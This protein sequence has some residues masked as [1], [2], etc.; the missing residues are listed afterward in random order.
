MI[1]IEN[2]EARDVATLPTKLGSEFYR[3]AFLL[4]GSP[5]ISIDIAVDT[6]ISQIDGQPFFAA[7]M[8][9][10]SRR[11]VIAKALAAIHNELAESARRTQTEPSE[12]MGAATSKVAAESGHYQTPDRGSAARNGCLSQGGGCAIDLRGRADC[13]RGHSA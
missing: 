4:T 8:R 6:A 13:R 5:D 11:N 1:E 9:A 2:R 10:R 3:L 7:W 12:K